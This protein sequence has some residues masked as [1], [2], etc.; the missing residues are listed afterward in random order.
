MPQGEQQTLLHLLPSLNQQINKYALTNYV[1]SRKGL[2]VLTALVETLLL[3]G[4]LL[5]VC[6]LSCILINHLVQFK[7]RTV[8]A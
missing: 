2:T 5:W 4:I 6:I 8:L 1:H 7:A 3:S